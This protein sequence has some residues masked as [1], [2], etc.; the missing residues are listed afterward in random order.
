MAYHYEQPE[1]AIEYDAAHDAVAIDHMRGSWGP[2]RRAWQPA[3]SFL[4]ERTMWDRRESF[5]W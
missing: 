5:S 1:C 4:Q 3:N 2:V